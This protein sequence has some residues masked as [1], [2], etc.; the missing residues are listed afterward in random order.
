M[1]LG[2]IFFQNLV[3]G[4]HLLDHILGTTTDAS[5]SSPKPPPTDEWLALDTIILSWIFSTSSKNLQQRLVVENPKTAKESWDI[6]SLIFNDNKRSRSIALK[7]ELRSM[8]LGDLSI[9]AYFRKI[10]NIA[11]VLSSLGSPISN[12]DVVNIALDGLPDKYQNVSDIIIHHEPFIDLKTVRSM[13]TTAEMC[14]ESRV[15]TTYVED[16]SSSPM[17]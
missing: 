8:K 1:H 4:Y 9:D 16:T 7:A 6:L 15:T 14:L 3:R 2:P 13:L 10:E 12:N 11:V 5:S 17:V